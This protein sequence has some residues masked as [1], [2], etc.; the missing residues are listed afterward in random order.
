MKRGIP[1]KGV[2]LFCL[3]F[4]LSIALPIQVIFGLNLDSDDNPQEPNQDKADS[5]PSI[6]SEKEI[7]DPE[8]LFYLG[9]TEEDGDSSRCFFQ[10]IAM[11]FPH[12]KNADAARLALSKFQFSKGMY[13][14]AVD[15]T[16][17]FIKSY[18]TGANTPELLWISGCSFL[19]ADQPDSALLKFKRI[20]EF[21]P[22]SIW[23]AWAELGIGDCLFDL[24]DYGQA[25]I[26]FQRILDDYRDSDVFAFAIFGL[27][28]CYRKLEEPE[29]ALLY[30]NLL[31][32]RY[33]ASLELL[34]NP[35]EIIDYRDQE[36][37]KNRAEQLAGVRYTIQLGLFAKKEE[38]SGLRDHLKKFGYSVK[39]ESKRIS[40]K[41]YH[42]VTSGSFVSYQEAR[43]LK[44]ELEW[45]TQR[46]Y[47]IVIE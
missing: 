45:K 29:Q 47:R 38:A 8:I 42:V 7:M 36:G 25:V 3:L 43:K 13:L 44:E 10:E 20:Q 27:I 39:I 40:G 19:A 18:Q 41:K 1:P 6:G 9:K 11:H 5:I 32:E 2:W 28:Q 33:P 12:W 35:N 23:A 26:E 15:M 24:R 30:H 22:G 4:V 14:T 37:D 17:E 46:S 31:K 34:Q 16:C 21:Y